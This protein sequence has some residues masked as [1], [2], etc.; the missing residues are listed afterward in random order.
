MS[1]VDAVLHHGSFV[2]TIRTSSSSCLIL[3]TF[4]AKPICE[5]GSP[6][7][8][9]FGCGMHLAGCL[10]GLFLN[11]ENVVNMFLQIVSKFLPNNTGHVPEESTLNFFTI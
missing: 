3:S 6:Y 2:Q 11:P 1:Q 7:L 4:L 8:S 10:L 9:Y 5:P